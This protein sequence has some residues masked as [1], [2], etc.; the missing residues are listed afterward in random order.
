[1]WLPLPI[2]FYIDNI[3]LLFFRKEDYPMKLHKF[4]ILLAALV[5]LSSIAV[6]ASSGGPTPVSQLH[7]GM[8]PV[9]SQQMVAYTSA[10]N[11]RTGPGPEYSRFT[12]VTGGAVVTVLEYRLK[13]IRIDTPSGQ[14]WIYTGYLSRDMAAAPLQSGTSSG[15]SGGGGKGGAVSVSGRTPQ[16]LLRADMFP[17]GSQAT[18]DFASHVNIR[19]GAGNE[20]TAF[21][22]LARGATVTVLEY[23]RLW[24]RVDTPSGQGWIFSGFL[25]NNAVLTARASGVS[26]GSDSG[27]GGVSAG[28]G[29]RTPNSQLHAGMF[30]VGSQQ[31][32]DYCHFLNVRRG[33]G[34]NHGAFTNL[35]RGNVITVQ[36]Y[37]GGWVRIDTDSGQG[38]IYAG[39]LRRP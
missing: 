1:M 26:S 20:H 22:H 2:L 13:W 34:V 27:I 4:L 16:S 14:G 39:Y 17:I 30:P 3:A 11:V 15:G 32:V 8:F 6:F 24:V 21:T 7:A 37:R 12:H 10:L 5:C 9:G 36:E 29:S 23:N 18:V 33:A 19:R 35:A 28:V 38:W 31:T 25:S